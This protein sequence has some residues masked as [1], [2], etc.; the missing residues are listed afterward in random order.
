MINCADMIK[1]LTPTWWDDTCDWWVTFDH[2]YRK[3]AVPEILTFESLTPSWKRGKFILL[4]LIPGPFVLLFQSKEN[5]N[6]VVMI[7]LVAIASLRWE[8]GWTWEVKNLRW[9]LWGHVRSSW[10]SDRRTTWRNTYPC[11]TKQVVVSDP[12]WRHVGLSYCY[13]PGTAFV[14]IRG[15]GCFWITI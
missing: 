6:H 8:R 3:P 9:I 10:P 4:F 5:Q 7:F 14:P 1:A 15:L 13:R 11:W 12:L 2:A